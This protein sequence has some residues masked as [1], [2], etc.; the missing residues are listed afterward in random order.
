MQLNTQ[1]GAHIPKD[2]LRILPNQQN[3][4]SPNLSENTPINHNHTLHTLD[5]IGCRYL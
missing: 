2:D 1:F 5:L 4:H 3:N